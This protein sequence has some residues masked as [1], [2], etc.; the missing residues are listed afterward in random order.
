[1]QTAPT[2]RETKR[3]YELELQL[4]ATDETHIIRAR[5]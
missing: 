2:E 4:G 3:R 5:G 1:M